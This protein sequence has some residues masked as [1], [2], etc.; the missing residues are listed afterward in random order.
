M[1]ALSKGQNGPLPAGPP[2][3]IGIG[4]SARRALGRSATGAVEHAGEVGI[5]DVGI[6]GAPARRR[7]VVDVVVSNRSMPA[8]ASVAELKLPGSAR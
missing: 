6:P 4:A 7:L 1:T 3:Q 8:A 2:V 5:G